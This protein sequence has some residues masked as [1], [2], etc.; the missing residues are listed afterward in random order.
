M[1]RILLVS[2]LLSMTAYLQAQIEEGFS[3]APTGWVL[4]Q[5]ASISNV[6]GNASVVTPGVG[7]NNPAVIGTPTVVK[8]S[9]SV[10]VCIDFLVYSSNLNS[11]VA[12]PCATFMD[13]LFVK[14]SVTDPRDAQDPA[15]IYARIDN[16]SLVAGTNCFSFNFPANVLVPDFKV[17]LSFHAGCTQ[18]GVRYVLDNVKISGVDEVCAGNACPPS[19]LNDVLVRTD[20]AELSFDAVLY[21]SNINY[22][23]AG[24]K[25]VDPGGTD[26]DPNDTYSHLRWTVVS[27]PVNGSVVINADGTCTITRSSTSVFDLTFVYRLCDDGADNDFNTT[28]DNLCDDATVT[29][30]YQSARLPV[31][32]ASFTAIRQHEEVTIKWSTTTESN[33]SRFELQ[34]SIANAAY[35]TI[36]MLNSKSVN[37]NSD[38]PLFYEFRENNISKQVTAYRLVQIDKDDT[39]TVYGSRLVRGL[40]GEVRMTVTPNPAVQGKVTILFDDVQPRNIAIVALNGKVIQEFNGYSHS[41]LS[42]NGLRIGMYIIRVA[43][44]DSGARLFQKLIVTD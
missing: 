31:L 1:K 42:V 24:S 16:Y 33:N 34:H 43:E 2:L 10:K 6:N 12:L 19:A 41:T 14:S 7:G 4:A 3:P 22:P 26:N 36:A 11:Q 29:V 15:N 32:L 40:G 25:A 18:S 5:G 44:K 17:F 21:G 39:R 23:A 35:Q 30:S 38:V 13:V 37:G 9:N 28:A 20:V 8:T 27:Q